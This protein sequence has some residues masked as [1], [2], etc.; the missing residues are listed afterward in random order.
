MVPVLAL[1]WAAAGRACGGSSFR[2][3]SNNVELS[4]R[5]PS[6]R[7]PGS[8]GEGVIAGPRT[9]AISTEAKRSEAGWGYG[10]GAREPADP[11][12]ATVANAAM[13]AA[14]ATTLGRRT[15]R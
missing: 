6:E 4:S 15:S 3:G 5:F 1:G 7:A 9:D 10:L 14:I 8:R 12:T 13:S 11:G 2:A